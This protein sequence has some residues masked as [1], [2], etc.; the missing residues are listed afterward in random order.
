[1]ANGMNDSQNSVNSTASNISQ[2]RSSQPKI[3]EMFASQ[4]EGVFGN[5]DLRNKSF[6]S[7][8][9]DESINTIAGSDINEV[10]A[11]NVAT[12]KL[13]MEQIQW[14]IKDGTMELEERLP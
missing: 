11:G 7:S 4:R 1:M 3:S 14:A 9:Q 12:L 2:A 5:Q 8:S 13:K 10:I 6:H